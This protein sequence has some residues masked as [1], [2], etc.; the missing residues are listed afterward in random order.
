V[1]ALT[2]TRVGPARVSLMDSERLQR[3]ARKW[4]FAW[5]CTAC[6]AGGADRTEAGAE[7]QALAH[8]EQQHAEPAP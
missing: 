8:E 3:C 4:P 5:W 7:A 1:S 6:P 2:V